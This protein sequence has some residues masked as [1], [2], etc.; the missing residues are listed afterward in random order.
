M[1]IPGIPVDREG[2]FIYSLLPRTQEVADR[3]LIEVTAKDNVKI[4]TLRSTY[5]VE[6][7]TLCPIDVVL[8]DGEGQLGSSVTLGEHQMILI[9]MQLILTHIID[10]GQDYAIPI[11]AV[12]AK[13]VK[14]RPHS[15]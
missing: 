7:K 13:N 6:N 9:C 8:V 5:K 1:A 12:L 2:E 14:V 3:L 10:P 11:E 4:V 15:K